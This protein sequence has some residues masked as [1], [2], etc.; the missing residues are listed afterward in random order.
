MQSSSSNVTTHKPLHKQYNAYWRLNHWVHVKLY[1]DGTIQG[2]KSWRKLIYS[3]FRQLADVLY[4]Y[5]FK[6]DKKTFDQDKDELGFATKPI[7]NKKKKNAADID[8]EKEEFLAKQRLMY[9][10]KAGLTEDKSVIDVVK[11]T[12]QL[13]NMQTQLPSY[14]KRFSELTIKHMR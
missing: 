11:I 9:I 13:V 14:K 5:P 10:N 3:Y 4:I 8:R 6:A 2:K 12:N 7:V 1:Q